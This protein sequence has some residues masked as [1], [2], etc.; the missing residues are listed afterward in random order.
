MEKIIKA[1]F[2]FIYILIIPS[3][4]L[5]Q[6]GWIKQQTNTKK[7]LTGIFFLDNNTGWA[8]GDSGIIL[9]TNNGGDYWNKQVYSVGS[10]MFSVLFINPSTGWVGGFT[11]SHLT[12]FLLKTTTGGFQ[13]TSI[14]MGEPYEIFTFRGDTIW[15]ATHTG[16]VACSTNGGYTW[17]FQEVNTHCELYTVYFVN[18]LIG[19]TGGG[20][21]QGQGYIYKTTNSGNSWFLQFIPLNNHV[22]SMYFINSL[23]GFAVTLNG[24]IYK[25]T[26]GGIDWTV[27]LSNV[28]YTLFRV[29]FPDSNTGYTTGTNNKILK[30]TNNGLNWINQLL[31]SNISSSTTYFQMS[32]TSPNVGWVVGDSGIILKTTNGGEPIGIQQISNQIPENYLLLQNYPNPFN[33]STQI[34][35]SIIKSSFIKLF[36]FNIEGKLIDILVNEYQLYGTYKVDFGGGNLSSGIYFYKIEAENFS[37]TKK[38]ILIK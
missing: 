19:W 5:A 33:S 31:P 6:S 26:T 38:M 10:F 18:P 15:C 17:T 32:F 37:D 13:W 9:N 23:T 36:I 34:E 24:Y 8:V 7:G 2:G 14:S 20:V 29:K 1:I 12:G 22:K 21:Y 27:L 3:I 11:N 25:T 28:N 16:F 4:V 35:Y 30:T